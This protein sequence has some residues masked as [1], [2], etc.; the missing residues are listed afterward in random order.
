MT[1]RHRRDEPTGQ[2]LAQLGE[3][4]RAIAVGDGASPSIA[5]DVAQE[6]L[7]RTLA[8]RERISAETLEPYAVATARNL[9]TDVRRDAQLERRHRHRLLEI[10]ESPEPE[11]R[12]LAAE[13]AAAVRSALDALD[14]PDRELLLAHHQGSSTSDLATQGGSTPAAVA[15]R[16]NRI[17]AR[18]RL[19]YLLALRR[20]RLPT[21]RCRPVLL[22]VSANDRRRQRAIGADRHLARCATCSALVPPL[23]ER[24][25]R[26]AGI[27]AAP[28]IALGGLGG[29]VTRALKT[30]AGQAGAAVTA[31]AVAGTCYGVVASGH[32]RPAVTSSPK[33]VA[34]PLL[35]TADGTRL[36][37]LPSTARL[38]ALVGQRVISDNAPVQSVVS[39]PGFWVGTSPSQR[40]Y[41]HIA[42]PEH[43]SKRVRAGQRLHFEGRLVANAPQF[44]ATDAVTAA[45]GASLLTAQTV[46]VEISAAQL[47]A[48]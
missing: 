18:M 2:Q 41:V 26:L 34:A 36:L 20:E 40:L 30:S 25:S 39:H 42:D 45:E 24:S 47:N 28:L 8:A 17:R 14:E 43:V 38:G 33:P 21:S 13:Q 35:R 32:P 48:R 1:G 7:A 11:A 6:S 44:A 15:M 27:A 3:R 10:P 12:L 9:L 23:V 16:L 22:A 29:R 5:D 46:H 19:D 37:P 31:A 4:L